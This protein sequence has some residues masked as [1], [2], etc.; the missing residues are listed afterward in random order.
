MSNSLE[1]FYFEHISLRE[2]FKEAEDKFMHK[3]ALQSFRTG[4]E[5]HPASYLMGT[6][7]SL[8][9]RLKCPVHETDHSLP[10]EPRMRK[11]GAIPPLPPTP[12]V[13]MACR[14]TSSVPAVKLILNRAFVF[15]VNLKDQ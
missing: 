5:S 3:D 6:W 12:C 1:T 14:G 15:A 4:S 9:P 10:L 13:V 11:S 2:I 7:G 8:S